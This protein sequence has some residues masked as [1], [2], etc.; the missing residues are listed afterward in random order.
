VRERLRHVRALEDLLDAT[1]VEPPE[2]RRDLRLRLIAPMQGAVALLPDTGEGSRVLD[3]SGS[4]GHV[5]SVHRLRGASVFLADH[6]DVQIHVA[7]IRGAAEQYVRVSGPRLPFERG[8]FDV[9]HLDLE[10]WLGRL[11]DATAADDLLS[12]AGRV[13]VPNG[14]MVL[15]APNP[16]D[17]RLLRG[18]RAGSSARTGASAALRYA[19]AYRRPLWPTRLRASGFPEA[20]TLVLWPHRVDRHVIGVPRAIRRQQAGGL[21]LDPAGLA[22]GPTWAR[23]FIRV[24]RMVAP[25]HCVVAGRGGVPAIATWADDL[26]GDAPAFEVRFGGVVA[27]GDHVIYKVGLSAEHQDAVDVE[28]ARTRRAQRGALA[29][30][31]PRT[32]RV[33]ERGGLRVAVIERGPRRC[34]PDQLADRV[35]AVLRAAPRGDRELGRTRAWRIANGEMWPRDIGIPVTVVRD[36]LEGLGQLKVPCGPSHGDLWWGNVLVR[37]DDTTLLID[38]DS[39]DA[40]APLFIDAVTAWLADREAVGSMA[41]DEAIDQLISGHLEGGLAPLVDE[42]RGELSHRQ[43]ALVRMA[44]WVG[45]H[46]RLTPGVLWP[47]YMRRLEQ[48]LRRCLR[49]AGTNGVRGPS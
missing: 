12:E 15:T 21:A 25:V 41:E 26:V 31:A 46:G 18:T 1:E 33:E 32:A 23:R 34:P 20:R 11:G 40:N 36:A 17:P 38:W 5:A 4:F 14:T 39:Y 48:Q 27:Y 24:S 49:A 28:I 13:L 10:S 42:L 45:N 22:G 7:T 3:L 6:D 8:S 37:A 35:S 19:R 9:V 44:A 47:E 43:V 30:F 2:R 29:R 16:R